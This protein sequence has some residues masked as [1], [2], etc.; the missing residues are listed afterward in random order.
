MRRVTLSLLALLTTVLAWAQPSE[1]SF[2]P[3]SS[4]LG[5]AARIEIG[6]VPAQTGDWIGIFDFDYNCAGAGQVQYFPGPGFAAAATQ[7]YATDIFGGG[8]IDGCPAMCEPFTLI[9][10]R[11]STG[12]FH[13]VP[14]NM[15]PISIPYVDAN[16]DSWVDG[17]SSI[18]MVVGGVT[19]NFSATPTNVLPVELFYFKGQLQ[20]EGVALNWATLSEVSNSHFNVEHSTDGQNFEVIGR[21]EGAGDHVGLLEYSFLDKFP[22]K[23]VNYYRL[24]QVDYDGHFEYSEVVPVQVDREEKDHVS[25]Y[26]NP[27]SGL[28]YL[29]LGGELSE[30]QLDISVHDLS[31]RVVYR[32]QQA[33]TGERVI[34]LP[35]DA[36]PAGYYMINVQTAGKVYA[37]K[38]IVH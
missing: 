23:G 25:L 14:N 9:L 2:I 29:G 7:I 35:L 1:F 17:Y 6:G 27:A 21:I 37:Q 24:Q 38:L 20:D 33:A 18:D 8:A 15:S 3:S 32:L 22:A 11:N 31:G 5:L 10:W 4:S 30:Q 19:L 16:D 13:Q 28:T 12:T 34:E 36:I 26:P